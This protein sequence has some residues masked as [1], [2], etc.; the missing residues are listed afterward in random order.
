MVRLKN[1]WIIVR[2]DEAKHMAL[3]VDAS[4]MKSLLPSKR[5]LFMLL[6]DGVTESFGITHSGALR[7]SRGE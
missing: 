4:K 2:V 3:S 1:R 5:D 7:E 6:S